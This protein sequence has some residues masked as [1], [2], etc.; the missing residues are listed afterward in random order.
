MDDV[1]VSHEELIAELSA[2]NPT[3]V[4]LAA[5]RITNRKLRDVLAKQAGEGLTQEDLKDEPF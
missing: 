2:I 1:P 4:E 3:L 5:L